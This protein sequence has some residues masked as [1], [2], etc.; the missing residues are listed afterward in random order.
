[1]LG[2]FAPILLGLL[3]V[4]AGLWL[5]WRSCRRAPE[6]ALA[7]CA[8]CRMPAEF[9]RNDFLCTGC[10]Q[11]VR[12]TG[13]TPA[14]VL[15]RGW[16]H[17]VVSVTLWAAVLAIGGSIFVATRNLRHD[18]SIS[19]QEMTFAPQQ[20]E[21][22]LRTAMVSLDLW[23]KHKPGELAGSGT[24]TL[25][26][27]ETFATLDL[28][29]ASQLATVTGDGGASSPRAP[30][31]PAVFDELARAAKLDPAEPRTRRQMAALRRQFEGVLTQTQ[32]GSGWSVSATADV[33]G[34]VS[35]GSS[36]SS[37]S[38]GPGNRWTFT[39][40]AALWLGGIGAVVFFQGHRARRCLRASGGAS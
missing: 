5:T 29:V 11:D 16:L 30:L 8:A 25:L 13:L 27:D 39:A 33:F 19:R 17:P 6:Q 23:Q 22:G 18:G 9:L 4:A 2:L 3:C 1:M 24:I 36:S 12:V 34:S 7:A 21:P 26:T 28:D 32:K 20:N 38:P 31:S 15:R 37:I 40:G 35:G 14:T 10:G